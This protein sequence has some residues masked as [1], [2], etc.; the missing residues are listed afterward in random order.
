MRTRK[1]EKNVIPNV[2]HYSHFHTRSGPDTLPILSP[3]LYHTSTLPHP[4]ST[5]MDNPEAES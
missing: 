2:E 4:T 5:T 1:R 3:F